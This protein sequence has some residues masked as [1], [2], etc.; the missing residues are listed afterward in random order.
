M[1][2]LISLRG[3]GKVFATEQLQTHALSNIDLD[4]QQGEFV[5]ICGP[6]GCGKSTLLSILGLL[7]PASSGQYQLAG[8]DVAAL[9]FDMAARFRNQH[10]GFVF[11]AFNLIDELTVAGNVALPLK[12]QQPKLSQQ[13]IQSRVQ[14]C[15]QQVGMVH[16]AAH[17]PKQLSGGQQQR[18]AIARALVT[19]PS[20]LL[21]DEATG[22][23]DSKSG[24]AVMQLIAN[25]H[26]E[27]STIC[28]VT[29]DTRY[30]DLASRQVHLFD[31][32]L[33]GMSHSLG[34]THLQGVK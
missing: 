16:R 28:M 29:H 24:D 17:F 19:K 13:A 11:Q 27:G 22:N 21:V 33:L 34:R 3:I 14:A 9:S 20:I 26:A 15:L 31:G 1:N 30:A 8:Q 10:I 23:L 5:S 12:Y 4:I 32:E 6:S 7:T 18:V 2:A 25:L